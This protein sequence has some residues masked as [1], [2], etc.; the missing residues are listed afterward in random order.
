MLSR[1]LAYKC[2]Y[3]PTDN[4]PLSARKLRYESLG[5]QNVVT[6]IEREAVLVRCT[7]LP[8]LCHTQPYFAKHNQDF[9]NRINDAI[10]LL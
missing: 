10:I 1:N 7:S 4:S 9:A 2:N 8:S 3:T 5:V 6:T